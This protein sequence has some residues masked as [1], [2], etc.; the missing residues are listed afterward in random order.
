MVTANKAEAVIPQSR[1][2]AVQVLDVQQELIGRFVLQIISVEGNACL[3]EEET[4][5]VQGVIPK[6][7]G[8]V[9]QI[10]DM[11]QAVLFRSRHGSHHPVCPFFNELAIGFI[12]VFLI[13]QRH[14]Q[15][16]CHGIHVFSGQSFGQVL[17][18][19]SSNITEHSRIIGRLV[20]LVHGVDGHTLRPFPSIHGHVI[21]GGTGSVASFQAIQHTGIKFLVILMQLQPL[22]VLRIFA[23][24]IAKCPRKSNHR[25]SKNICCKNVNSLGKG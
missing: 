23:T 4:G 8:V 2:G 13:E 22:L 15:H 10:S 19:P 1:F 7:L 16:R 25:K 18:I 12:A 3:I 11:L 24:S 17:V 6:L 9:F 21:V 14:G 20:Q 5:H